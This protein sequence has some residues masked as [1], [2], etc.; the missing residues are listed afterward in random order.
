MCKKELT[1]LLLLL[2]GEDR[3]ERKAASTEKFQLKDKLLCQ[4]SF[5]DWMLLRTELH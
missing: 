4:I 3:R 2:R 5:S 1:V